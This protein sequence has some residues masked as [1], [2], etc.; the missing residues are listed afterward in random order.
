MWR[1][2]RHHPTQQRSP[3]QRQQSSAKR[4]SYL[5]A[6]SHHSTTGDRS[7]TGG[8][9]PLTPWGSQGPWQALGGLTRLLP[10]LHPMDPEG[11][12]GLTDRTVVQSAGDGLRVLE[13][14]STPKTLLKEEWQMPADQSMPVVRRF[15][16]AIDKVWPA[17]L[18]RPK[19]ARSAGF[20]KLHLNCR[21][22]FSR[23]KL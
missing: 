17:A 2:Q 15:E 11:A 7:T 22:P 19:C 3:K 12:Q 16:V 13:S 5:L 8:E 14:P 6:W 4:A 1:R 21:S 9:E 20:L 23:F 10:R 18:M